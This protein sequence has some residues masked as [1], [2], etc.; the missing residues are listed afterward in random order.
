MELTNSLF[1]TDQT[2]GL[3]CCRIWLYHR[4]AFRGLVAL[5]WTVI[6]FSILT[7]SPDMLNLHYSDVIIQLW[8]CAGKMYYIVQNLNHF[9]HLQHQRRVMDGSLGTFM[10]AAF[11]ASTTMHVEQLLSQVRKGNSSPLENDSHHFCLE[12]KEIEYT[13]GCFIFHCLSAQKSPRSL[14]CVRNCA[15]S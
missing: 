13:A 6:N 5:W 3:M 11:C 15:M 14:F 7:S 2:T 10:M 9:W 1:N 12:K 4:T 8:K